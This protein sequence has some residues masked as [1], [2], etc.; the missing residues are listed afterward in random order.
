MINWCTFERFKGMTY[1]EQ[2]K[3]FV[4]VLI[5]MKRF[6]SREMRCMGVS[7]YNKAHIQTC[8][9]MLQRIICHDDRFIKFIN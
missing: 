6:E 9:D 8:S 2:I 4:Q 3:F 5:M 7:S 1:M